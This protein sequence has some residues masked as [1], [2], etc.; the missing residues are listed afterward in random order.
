MRK[1]LYWS[2]YCV[3]LLVVAGLAGCSSDGEQTEGVQAPF[4]GVHV[5]EGLVSEATGGNYVLVIGDESYGLEGN[6]DEIKQF[7][8]Q[9]V[10]VSASIE[11][12][13]LRV[14]R[15]GP[16]ARPSPEG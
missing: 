15:I 16:P 13:T 1:F 10:E 3:A 11:G 9:T 12:N 2:F 7:V 14:V 6:N 5:F 8:G 4:S